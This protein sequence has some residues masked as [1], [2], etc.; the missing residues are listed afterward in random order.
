MPRSASWHARL[1]P[2]AACGVEQMEARCTRLLPG[3]RS[4]RGDLFKNPDMWNAEAPGACQS[5]SERGGGGTTPL[6]S[7]GRAR[8]ES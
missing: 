5:V 1:R 4:C 7:E 8:Y 3:S 2:V 6:D